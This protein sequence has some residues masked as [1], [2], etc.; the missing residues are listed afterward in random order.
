MTLA[1]ARIATLAGAAGAVNVSSE[2]QLI[3][4]TLPGVLLQTAAGEG[5]GGADPSTI[6]L[7]LLMVESSFQFCCHSCSPPRTLFFTILPRP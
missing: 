7:V 4:S 3:G 6:R 2:R 5:G 1:I